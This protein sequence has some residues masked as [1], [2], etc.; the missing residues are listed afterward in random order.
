MSMLVGGVAGAILW[1]ASAPLMSRFVA[2]RRR[3]VAVWST[4]VTVLSALACRTWG[5]S[6]IGAA[7]V[8]LVVGFVVLAEIDI[9]CRRLPREIS[10][11]LA[12]VALVL[13]ALSAVSEGET[14]PLLDAL[15]G[16]LVATSS[17]FV[18]YAMSR[19]GLGDGDVRLAPALGTAAAFGGIGTL[20]VTMLVAF[21]AAGVFVVTGLALG[22]MNRSSAIPFGPFLIGGSLVAM[23]IS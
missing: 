10:Y 14:Q 23:L 9:G 8:V 15:A 12:V 18:L 22:R 19:G 3:S 4:I 7:A 20:W 2:R 6:W 5:L 21:V 16:V 17:M 1:L 13:V 11:P